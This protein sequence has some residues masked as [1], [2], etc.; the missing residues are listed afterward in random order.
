MELMEYLHLRDKAA[1]IRSTTLDH[2]R[3]E[4]NAF[5]IFLRDYMSC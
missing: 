5:D 4:A 3:R 1:S 2:A